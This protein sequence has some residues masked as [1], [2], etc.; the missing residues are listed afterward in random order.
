MTREPFLGKLVFD[1]GLDYILSVWHDSL[2]RFLYVW[3]RLRKLHDSRLNNG[4]KRNKNTNIF[5]FAFI[6]LVR[7]RDINN[8][9]FFLSVWWQTIRS[10][11]LQPIIYNASRS[12][13]S[14][15]ISPIVIQT[16]H[17]ISSSKHF[18]RKA[19]LFCSTC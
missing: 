1:R 19:L 6:V 8:L 14:R 2:L 17:N 11:F 5:T 15:K 12:Y 9:L 7:T 10:Q 16:D 4:R 18:Q 13:R 3:Q